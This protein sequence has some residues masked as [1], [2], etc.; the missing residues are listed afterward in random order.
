[1]KTV[2]T[3][4]AAY[5]LALPV[6]DALAQRFDS[7]EHRAAHEHGWMFNYDGAKALARKTNRPMMIVFRCV[8]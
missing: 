1:M 8:P 5:L 3:A 2:V 6:G 4:A 7:S